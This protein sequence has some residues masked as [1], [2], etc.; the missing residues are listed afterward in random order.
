MRKGHVEK[1]VN[2]V[3]YIKGYVWK[4]SYMH[5]FKMAVDRF[6]K[7]GVYLIDF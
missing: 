5:R 6:F 2:K 1:Q 4:P 3:D 7:L